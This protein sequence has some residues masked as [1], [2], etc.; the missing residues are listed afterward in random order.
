[1]NLIRLIST[2]IAVTPAFCGPTSGADLVSGEDDSATV[3]NCGTQ[4]FNLAYHDEDPRS[5]TD[6]YR[7]VGESSGEWTQLLTVQRLKPERAATPAQLM[8]FLEAHRESAG[9]DPL[10]VEGQGSRACVFRAEI[11]G[12]DGGSPLRVVGLVVD[13]GAG[14]ATPSLVVIH[15]TAKVSP[16]GRAQVEKSCAEWRQRFLNQAA[17]ANAAALPGR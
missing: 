15:F 17:Q 7:L 4:S 9:W 11:A 6:E 12:R 14:E 3:V 10:V 1:M 13:Q 5:E 8:E 16:N 2:A